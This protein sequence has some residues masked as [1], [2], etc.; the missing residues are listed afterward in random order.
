MIQI[1]LPENT[2]YQRNGDIT[3]LPT[4][5]TVHV[6]LNGNWTVTL[7]HPIDAEG[8]WKYIE[9]HAV[10]KMMSFNG[11]QLFRV[12]AKKKRE[13]EIQATLEPVF[14]DALGECF[15]LDVRPTEKTGQ[16]ALNIMLEGFP[17]YQAESDIQKVETAYY[18]NKNL[19]EAVN[20]EE[21]NSFV[22]R[23]GGEIL[24]DNYKIVVNERVGSDH[25]TQILYGKNIAKDG[26]LEE[27]DMRNIVTRIFPQAYNG[28]MM[29]RETPWVDSDLLHV[30]PIIYSEL[31]KF[32][33]VK[34]REDAQ[35]DDAEKG[36]IVCETQEELEEVLIQKCKDKFKEGIDKPKVN[37]SID[38]IHLAGTREY[39]DVKELE[40][41]SLGDTVHCRHE[42]L[43]VITD[44]RVIELEYDAIRERIDTIE[45]G[46]YRYDYFGEMSR[47]AARVGETIRPD[48]TVVAEQV[49]GEMSDIKGRTLTLG[50]GETSGSVEIRNA[51]KHMVGGVTDGGELFDGDLKIWAIER[52]IL[53]PGIGLAV[54]QRNALS[55][56]A[57]FSDE[58]YLEFENGILVKGQTTNGE[59]V[60]DRA[61][62][63]GRAR[64]VPY[65]LIENG[66]ECA[67]KLSQQ[68]GWSRNAIVAWLGNVQ[69]ESTLD[70]AAFQGGEGNWSQGVGYVQWTPGTNLQE[71]AQAIGR[72]DYLTTDCQ[73]AVID[74]ERK[75][76]IQYYPTAAYDLT[77]DEFIRSNA[78]V[79]WLTMA[80]LKNYER[81]GDEA[82]ENR[83][84]YAREWNQ[85]IDGILKN[86]VEEAVKWAIDIA[87]DESHGYDQANR[88]GPDYDCSSLL[89]QAW[90]NA[91]V[92]VKSN[93]AT[94]TGNMR[95]VF[96]KCGFE[97]VTNEVNMVTG[98]G[99]QRG[100]I[101][102]NIV[103]H[104]AMGIGNGQIVQASQNEFG[105]TTGGQ[106][107]DQTGEE[108][109][110]RSYYN[111]PW[112]CILRY[113]QY[114]G[115]DPGQGLAFVKWIPKGGREIN[116]SD[117]NLT[118]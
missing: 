107:G 16:E 12:K 8:R 45:L 117:K 79:E 19:I 89:I 27:V 39:E 62:F 67:R 110:T 68:Y 59:I 54:N 63:A 33:D 71:R 24:Y 105:G 53:S 111:Y 22:N 18:I 26:L 100:D 31:I 6:V 78:E 1:Y 52:I 56:K 101:L 30:Y 36:I 2:N 58:S 15:L 95:E 43:G 28:R 81:A 35:E 38:M 40:K 93:G 47:M 46:D 5:A 37:L 13:S 65:G 29:Q 34:M 82:V 113:P 57:L 69:Q 4:V 41:V 76:G 112:D 73:L 25:G 9:D 91:G 99:V 96:L 88:W 21:E 98:A 66:T 17:K 83:L 70:P 42:K 74:Y 114:S 80:W 60:E 115:P 61:R 108:I 3:L 48:G 104:T 49:Y 50:G 44:A 10:V 106:T 103:N 118:D 87:N 75:N 92:P 32:D 116:G 72:T 20:G 7:K 90:E 51:R 14:M 102:L 55:G 23:W 94:Y 97:D 109:A 11:E 85:R 77:F 84:Q 86:A 64:Q